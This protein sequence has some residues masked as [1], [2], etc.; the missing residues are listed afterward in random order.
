[1]HTK[2]E[3]S[4]AQVLSMDTR[5]QGTTVEG[6]RQWIVV[7]TENGMMFCYKLLISPP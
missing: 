2:T 4:Q 1:M 7:Y 5:G 3:Q 6:Y